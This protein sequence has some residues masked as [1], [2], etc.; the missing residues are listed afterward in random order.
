[1]ALA[2]ARELLLADRGFWGFRAWQA[3][4]SSGAELLWRARSNLILAVEEVLEDGSYRSRICH[5]TDRKRTNPVEVRVIEYEL[6]DPAL[7]S[8][9]RYRLATTI[10]DPTRA[11]A[12]ELA[13]AYPNRWEF[14]TALDELKTHQRGARVVLR[15]KRRP[16]A[17]TRRSTATCSSTTRSAP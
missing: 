3:A 2:R 13:A 15:S 11:S 4:R 9:E 6:D 1:M 5:S 7:G 8:S 16:R 12:A 17:S 10:I 14:E